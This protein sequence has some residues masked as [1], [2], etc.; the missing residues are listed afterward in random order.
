MKMQGGKVKCPGPHTEGGSII[1]IRRIYLTVQLKR[2]G[3]IMTRYM[4]MNLRGG[5][6]MKKTLAII[7][8]HQ[9]AIRFSQHLQ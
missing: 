5:E 7:C 1:L 2:K 3:E 8:L 6:D 9:T 4:W